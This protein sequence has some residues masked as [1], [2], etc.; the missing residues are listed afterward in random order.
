MP[1]QTSILLVDDDPEIL[2]T[3]S[4]LLN[5]NGYHVI[6]ADSGKKT[7]EQLQ[8]AKP[9]LVLLDVILPD[10]NGIDLC[11]QIKEEDKANDLFVVL[12]SGVQNTPDHK[13]KGLDA[14]ADGFI[15]RPFHIQ[16][17]LSRINAFSRLKKSQKQLKK[18]E[19]RKNAILKGTNA[20]TW[21]W[22]V[23]TGEIITNERWAQMLGYR[24]QELQP[25]TFT[26]WQQ[27]LHPVDLKKAQEKLTRHFNGEIKFYECEFRMKHKNGNWIWVLDCGAV[28]ERTQDGKPLWMFGTHSDITSLKQSQHKLEI[29]KRKL[30]Q[31]NKEMNCLFSL[32][33]I[34][35]KKEQALEDILQQFVSI[36]PKAFSSPKHTSARINYQKQRFTSESFFES[37]YKLKKSIDVQGNT[38]GSLEV[39]IKPFSTKEKTCGFLEN[40][41]RLVNS[42]AERIGQI[43]EI[44]ESKASLLKQR[45]ELELNRNLLHSIFQSLPGMLLVVDRQYRLLLA[46]ENRIQA[47]GI[48]NQTINSLLGKKCYE[49]FLN[50]GKPCPSCKLQ[51]VL[52]NG[53]SLSDI[54]NP[55]DPRVQSSGKAFQILYAPVK[56][57]AEEVIG[58]LEYSLDITE[59]RDAKLKAQKANKTKS[60][61]LSTMSHELRTP[62]NGVIGF[63]Q[64]L[65][66]TA[67]DATQKDYLDVILT[68]SKNLLD[69]ISDILDLTKLEAEMTRLTPETINLEPIIQKTIAQFNYKIKEKDIKLE[70]FISDKC[71]KQIRIDQAR[72][73]QILLNLLSNAIK[74]TNQGEVTLRVTP[75]N[76]DEER[77][78]VTLLFSVKD[79]GIGIKTEDIDRIL[80]PFTQVD[81]SNTRKYQGT[82]LGLSIVNRLLQKMDSQL[83]IES[84]HGEGSIFYFM[85]TL[86]YNKEEVIFDTPTKNKVDP[87]ADYKNKTIL[88]AED[89][90]IN[91]FY[92]RTVI[93]KFFKNIQILEAKNGNEAYQLFLEHKPDLILMDIVM[94]VIDGY[95]A[96]KMIRMQN[97]SVPIF[98]MTAKSSK[99]EREKCLKSGMTDYLPKPITLDKLK[100]TIKRSLAFS[101]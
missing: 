11:K 91:M 21:E 42:L 74:F 62:L 37:Q 99:R 70:V 65:Q 40:E 13:S 25:L 72:L 76:I 41:K 35:Q 1:E 77:Q 23:Q 50:R 94:P 32:T 26:N 19:E 84:V 89:N 6:Q 10:I 2:Y 87:N 14:G 79:T 82:G 101:I 55:E 30:L 92:A 45:E 78:K 56:N 28:L 5:K 39:F 57:K 83:H 27:L 9:D 4:H 24:H 18:S 49:I 15:A 31:T 64:L 33:E 52:Q 53:K 86:P 85:L 100:E 75:K 16:E 43:A 88:I 95:K 80:Q 3:T 69:L 98:A 96:T 22:N 60:E 61:F 81:M 48:Q 36:L 34:V 20:G 97:Q 90:S 73:K 46:N 47:M 93:S 8:K 67:L 51:T 63:S 58:V 29:Q 17:F 38:S 54:T 68:S 66:H 44:K 71:P 59:L 12:I 7:L